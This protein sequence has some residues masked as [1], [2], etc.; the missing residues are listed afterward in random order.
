MPPPED[1]PEGSVGIVCHGP[2]RCGPRTC[3][4]D[5][6]CD[7]GRCVERWLCISTHSCSGPNPEPQLE[8]VEGECNAN[9][10]CNSERATCRPVRVCVGGHV[11][12]DYGPYQDDRDCSCSTPT[13][14]ASAVP[15]LAFV[16]AGWLLG[17]RR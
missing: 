12:P 3:T 1:C 2:R 16:V 9:G 7:G 14:A 10:A 6:E 11:E 4:Q 13:G 8:H 5:S 15:L 17:R